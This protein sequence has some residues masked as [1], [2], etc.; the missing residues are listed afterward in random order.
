M[1]SDE[2]PATGDAI[3]P[4]RAEERR[5]EEREAD[6]KADAERALGLFAC[7]RCGAR[8]SESERLTCD[9]CR[10]PG[11]VRCQAFDADGGHYCEKDCQIACYRELIGQAKKYAADAEQLYMERIK[12]LEGE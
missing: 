9:Y 7:S 6:R 4:T 11:C 12:A 8:V 2:R 10:K 3:G 1:P 5:M